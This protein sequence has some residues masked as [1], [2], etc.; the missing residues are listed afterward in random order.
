M[1][2]IPRLGLCFVLPLT[3]CGGKSD[4]ADDPSHSRYNVMPGPDGSIFVRTS[5]GSA[6]VRSGDAGAALPAGLPAYP[7]GTTIASTAV[8]PEGAPRP[9][10]TL[11]FR[12]SDA[13]PAIAA[14]YK[15]AATKAGY[16][17]DSE[18]AMPG[19]TMIGGRRTDGAEFSLTLV[20]ANAATEAT[21]TAGSTPNAN[22]P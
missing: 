8:T 4:A 10:T 2:L 13:P 17:L 22:Q 19:L 3:G 20:P 5:A 14:F 11:S 9:T 1:K 16:A 15:G 21:L 12:T 7:N 6:R 18:L